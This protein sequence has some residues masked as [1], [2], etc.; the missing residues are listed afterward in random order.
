MKT[1]H[2]KTFK[3]GA[4]APILLATALAPSLLAA[5]VLEEVVVT[6]QKREESIQDVPLSVTALSGRQIDALGLKDFTEVT[7]QMPSVQLNTYSPKFTIFNLRGVSQNNFND[8]LEAPV[9]VYLDEVYR[10][11]MNGLS[12]QLFDMERVEVLRGPQG[13]LF[14]RNATGGLIHYVSRGADEEETNGY[15]EAEF[16]NYGRYAVE[17]AVGGGLSDTIRYRVAGRWNVQD[18]YVEAAPGSSGQDIGGADGYALRGTLQ[19]DFSDD[20]QGNLWIKYDED[21]DVPTG[22][23]T[24]EIASKTSSVGPSPSAILPPT[25]TPINPPALMPTTATIPAS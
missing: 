22:R 1:L 20:L 18:G 10:A 4:L 17:G 9:A 11:T 3:T 8:N 12:G 25:G 15:L 21:S 2:R 19:M 7:Q 6:A 13:T 16:G 24:T 5:Q 23:Q 14:G